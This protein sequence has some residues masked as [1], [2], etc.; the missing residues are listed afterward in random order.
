MVEN[1]ALIDN[2]T[3]SSVE[4]IIGN[5]PVSSKDNIDGDISA[6]ESFITAILFYDN[7]IA[8]DNYIPK[9]A[10]SRKDT[11]KE[12]NFINPSELNGNE[13]DDLSKKE[14]SLINPKIE[15]GKFVDQDYE[16]F[17]ELLKINIRCT[18]DISSSIYYLTLKMLGDQSGFE[19]EKYSQICHL[20]FSEYNEKKQSSS[21][22]PIKQVTL[23]D[24]YGKLISDGYRIPDAKWGT[25]ETGRLSTGLYAFIAALNWLSYKSIYYTNYASFLKADTFLHPIRQKFQLYYFDKINNYNSNYILNFLKKFESLVN[26]EMGFLT[27]SSRACYIKY[28]M[29][30]FL[31]YIISQTKSVTE[32]IDYAWEL[33]EKKFF[34]NVR[35]QLGEIRELYEE[36][37]LSRASRKRQKITSQLKSVFNELRREYGLETIQGDNLYNG[38]TVINSAV[39][40]VTKIPSIVSQIKNH[41]IVN[42]ISKCLSRNSFSMIYRD[43]YRELY[44]IQKLGEYHD[45]LTSQVQVKSNIPTHN[46][47]TEEVKW[48][49]YHSEFKSPM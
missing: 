38:M 5:I 1:I 27:N 11:F 37:K 10:N 20:I 33:R 2:S 45:M 4:R 17:F 48:M 23:I 12:I 3:L 25:G 30:H 15:A 14:A 47:K 39:S 31:T 46:P 24:K 36:E 49:N 16:K 41:R 35:E 13:I 21:N 42:I 29:P 44:N 32:I 26:D 18:W 34:I 19:F 40:S 7:H 8:I 22:L 9:Y 43:L 6:F 28:T